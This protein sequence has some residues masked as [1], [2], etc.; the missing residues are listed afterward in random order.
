MSERERKNE[1]ERNRERDPGADEGKSKEDLLV[2]LG[3][4][5]KPLKD[6]TW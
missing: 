1:R 5:L 3:F 4:L 2:I 6:L